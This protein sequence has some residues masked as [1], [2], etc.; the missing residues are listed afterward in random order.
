MKKHKFLTLTEVINQ[1]SNAPIYAINNSPMSVIE[2]AGELTIP[3]PKPNGA[4]YNHLFI[5]MTWLPVELTS[6]IPR[7]QLLQSVEL[8]QALNDGLI[9]LISEK[10]A[11]SLNSESGAK[12]ERKRLND[13]RKQTQLNVSRSMTDNQAEVITGAPAQATGFSD[14]FTNWVER[15]VTQPDRKILNEVRIRR[16]FKLSEIKYMISS[17]HEKTET[18]QMLNEMLAQRRAAKKKKVAKESA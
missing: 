5:P 8:R 10:S 14:S 13:L 18:I 4:G 7:D 1:D 9:G 3:V 16:V 11:N 15:M 12:Q 2:R 6:Q 17:F